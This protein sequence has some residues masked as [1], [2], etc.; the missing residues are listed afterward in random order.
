[1][2]DSQIAAVVTAVLV[3]F[4]CAPI[5]LHPLDCILNLLAAGTRFFTESL[6]SAHDRACVSTPALIEGTRL[7]I[8]PR[9]GCS[10]LCRKLK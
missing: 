7:S 4:P 8:C 6:R 10:P 1:M 9:F 2:E 3:A 5:E